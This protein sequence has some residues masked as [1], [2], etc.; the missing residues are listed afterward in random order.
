M[1][2]RIIFLL[3]ALLAGGFVTAHDVF[4]KS[5]P[6]STRK[7]INAPEKT[8]QAPYSDGILAGNTLYLAG[9]MG[10]PNTRYI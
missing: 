6:Q 8:V 10:N 9:R 7:A 4:S 3:S 5:A 1:N 2:R